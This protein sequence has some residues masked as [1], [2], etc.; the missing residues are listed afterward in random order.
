MAQR[1]QYGNSKVKK[2]LFN[3]GLPRIFADYVIISEIT[4]GKVAFGGRICRI[5]G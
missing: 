4:L 3:H 5:G 2:G 1:G